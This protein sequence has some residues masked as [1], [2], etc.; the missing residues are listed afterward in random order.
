VDETVVWIDSEQCWRDAA[1]DPGSNELL[2]V[3]VQPAASVYLVRAF[4]E[5]LRDDHHVDDAESLIDGSESLP[6]RVLVNNMLSVTASIAD[7]IP[8]E[9]GTGWCL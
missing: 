3:G 7:R 4:V 5:R 8:P 1:V 9:I 2:F 6:A